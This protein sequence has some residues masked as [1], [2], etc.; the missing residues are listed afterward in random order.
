MTRDTKSKIFFS[1]IGTALFLLGIIALIL[2]A[3]TPIAEREPGS[4]SC[5]EACEEFLAAL[6]ERG[7]TV[8]PAGVIKPPFF[9]VQGRMITVRAVGVDVDIQIYEYSNADEARSDAEKI[10]ADGST[11]GEIA[12]SWIA[13]P[14]FFM[15]GRLIA[16]YLGDD[17]EALELFASVLGAPF[18]GSLGILEPQ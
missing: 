11:I 7:A 3:V 16:L 9:A 6:E 8:T 14:H 2:G 17:P 4:E 10:S 13:A 1:P 18:A 12:I 15:N 5:V